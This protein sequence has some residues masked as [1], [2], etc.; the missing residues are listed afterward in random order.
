MKTLKLIAVLIVLPLCLGLF[1]AWELQRST[2]NSLYL[3]DTRAN[4]KDIRSQ[5]EEMAA[6]PGSRS[7]SIDFDGQRVGVELALSRVTEAESELNTL[8]P[9]DSVMNGLAKAVIA[10]GLLATLVGAAGMLGLGWAGSRALRS[11]E[12]LL[13]TFSRV[14]RILPFVLVGHIIAMA[15]AVAAIL[16][17]EGLGLWHMGRM[18]SGELKLMLAALMVGA[19]CLYSIWTVGKQLGV[20]LSMFES[21]PMQV[22]GQAV[23]PQE[24]PGLWAFVSDL[25][26]RLGALA[27]DH[28]VLGMTEGFYVTSSDVDLLPSATQLKGRTLHVP[29]MY[30]GLLDSAET[31]AV[32]GH[33]LS[34]FA[35][36]DTEYSL[37]FLPIYDG[38][39]R[40]L[41]VIASTMLSSDLL[42]RTILR[43]AFMLG[44]YFMERFDHAV[45]HW[46]RVRELAADA[47]GA[48]LSG[49]GAAA[50]A[51][52]RISAIDPVLQES[53]WGHVAK[54]TNPTPE[55]TMTRDLPT[56]VL[57]ELGIQPLTLPEEE[58]AT[59][60]PHPSDTHPSNGE[61]IAS[62]QVSVADAVVNGT[63]AVDAAQACVALDG[64]FADP[65]ALRARITEDFLNHYVSRDAA[66]VEE[67]RTHAS[68]VTGDVVLHEGARVRG[69]ITLIILG[70]FVLVGVAV[71]ALPFLFPEKLGGEKAMIFIVGGA[72]IGVMLFVLPYSLRLYRRAD[73]TALSLTPDHF[74]FAN[75]KAPIPT[76]HIADFGLQVGQGVVL[77]ILLEDDA[78][79]PE[80][81]SRS[82]FA[83]GAKVLKKQ[84]WVQLQLTQFCRDNKKLKDQELADLIGTYLSAGTARHI[85]QQRF[86][87]T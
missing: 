78:P 26:E 27:P 17:Y 8:Q 85:L 67:L 59:Q 15:A 30:L 76:R 82:F 34:H 74:A 4:L 62:L 58:L 12:Q 87:K 37:R 43:P 31:S 63:R 51:L 69:I 80:V 60:L 71:L 65:Q 33:E 7:I 28:I 11:R 50:S 79:L 20:M 24:A 83:P 86:E 47:A 13:A 35:G 77:N 16:A 73:K 48:Q 45:N 61:R 75:L 70:L 49:N 64:Y 32:I 5:L 39:G 36:A 54:A 25:A 81:A 22:L 52:L 68:N 3:I 21:T 44:V 23:S 46:S 42:Q 57:H 40:S 56:T 84:R 9:L 66:V 72:L 14:S 1:G 38:I 41:G 6:K 29:M 53:V 19:V 10:L 2:E 18:S 55:H